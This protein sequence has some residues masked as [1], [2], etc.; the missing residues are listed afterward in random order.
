MS[1]LEN[2]F[3]SGAMVQ[4]SSESPTFFL[5]G[6]EDAII[7]SILKGMFEHP[8]LEEGPVYIYSD[9][10]AG[11]E[12]FPCISRGKVISRKVSSPK[13]ERRSNEVTRPWDL[14]WVGMWCG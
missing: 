11:G 14:G 8:G 1:T 6:Q 9:C 13:N 3:S 12:P 10:V 5:Q 4:D 2:V 7:S